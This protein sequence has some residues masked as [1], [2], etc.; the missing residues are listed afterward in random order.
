MSEA[1]AWPWEALM[2]NPGPFAPKGEWAEVSK[3]LDSLNGKTGYRTAAEWF[4]WKKELRPEGGTNRDWCRSSLQWMAKNFNENLA[5]DSSLKEV[6]DQLSDIEK[7]ATELAKALKTMSPTAA[8][9]LMVSAKIDYEDSDYLMEQLAAGIVSREH[10]TNAIV[11]K[12]M[13][14]KHR[15]REAW[16]EYH[17]SGQPLEAMQVKHGPLLTVETI[18]LCANAGVKVA[19]IERSR[20]NERDGVKTRAMGRSPLVELALL[21]IKVWPDFSNGTPANRSDGKNPPADSCSRFVQVMHQYATGEPLFN[22]NGEFNINPE[23]SMRQ[24][25]IAWKRQHQSAA[26]EQHLIHPAG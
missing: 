13:L 16:E 14:P 22:A 20:L 5:R 15:K 26:F 12:I 8:E 23:S 17:Q 25:L 21:C 11:Q 4:A 19:G 9:Y 1:P 2:P 10:A 7:A 18:A 6:T 3:F 24:A